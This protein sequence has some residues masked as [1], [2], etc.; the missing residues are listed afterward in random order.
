MSGA[1]ATPTKPSLA[2]LRAAR[3]EWQRTLENEGLRRVP[4]A[5]VVLVPANRRR[6]VPL[7]AAVRD[8]V[9]TRLQ[10][11]L[12]VVDAAAVHGAAVPQTAVRTAEAQLDEVQLLE[13]RAECPPSA[14]AASACG[15]CRGACCTAGGEHAFLRGEHLALLR[16]SA[17]GE[18]A[19]AFVARYLAHL[20]ARHYQRSCVFHA[21]GGCT[22]PRTMRSGLCNRYQCGALTQLARAV[23]APREDAEAGSRPVLLASSAGA[24][25]VRWRQVTTPAMS[26]PP[27]GPLA[28]DPGPP[29]VV[30]RNA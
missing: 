23:S 3:A 2:A 21:V 28:S 14:S 7:S 29:R 17:L 4:G 13:A 5:L 25:P 1:D 15:L 20:P 10:A 26:A 19:D 6:T 18:K 27:T 12:A 22:L 8:R 24:A 16:R 9:R 30:A 11:E